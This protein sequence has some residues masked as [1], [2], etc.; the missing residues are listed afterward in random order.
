MVTDSQQP[1]VEL[2]SWFDTEVGQ[3]A[4]KWE[5]LKIDALVADV[6]GYRAIQIGLPKVDLLRQNRMPFKAFVGRT[7][8]E[9]DVHH[10]WQA[11]VVAE[12][13]YLP[14]ESDSIDLLILPHALECAHDQHA[15]LR[16]VQRVLVP[17]GRVVISG[18]NP[19]SLWGFRHNL[20]FSKPWL[21]TS[22]DDDVA[23]NK[24]KDWLRLLS[25]EIDRGHFGCYAPALTSQKWLERFT[26]ME[27][28]GDR[29]WPIF[30]SVYVVSA[31][32]KVA[33]MHL[34]TP[35][36]KRQK[37]RRYSNQTVGATYQKSRNMAE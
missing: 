19:H 16:E 23:P 1:I 34:I 3:Y 10:A 14:L 12:P 24:I 29:W 11:S 17:E 31:V 2:Q 26:F 36:W 30:G 6:F 4:M 35:N 32:K 7:A 21:P 22:S 20:P 28:A 8:I 5:Q 9:P 13:E 25:F 15:L 18:F 33:S 27:P 37:K